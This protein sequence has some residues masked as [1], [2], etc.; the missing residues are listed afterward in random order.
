MLTTSTATQTAWASGGYVAGNKA[1][2]R[3]TVQKLAV[4]FHDY[5]LAKVVGLDLKGHGYFTSLYWGQTDVPAELP[6]L[7]SIKWARNVEQD[8]ATCTIELYNTAPLPLGTTPSDDH[9]WEQ[10]GFYSL[11]RGTGSNRWGY[12]VTGWGD[13]L[14]PDRIIRTYQGYGANYLVPPEQDP[15]LYPSGVWMIDKVNL[16]VN[17]ILTLECRDIGRVLLEQIAMPPVVP[18][19]QYPVSWTRALDVNNDGEIDETDPAWFRPNYG[20]DSNKDYVGHGI[21]DA[22]VPV[23]SSGGAVAGHKGEDAFDSSGTSYWLSVGERPNSDQAYPFVQGTFGSKTISAVRVKA[24]GGPYVMFIS[25]YADGE[26]KGRAKIPYEAGS[27]VD[28]SADIKFVKK[29]VVKLGEDRKVKLPRAYDDAT[30]IRLTF[31]DLWNSD[32][33]TNRRYRA[34]VKDVK[35]LGG[36]DVPVNAPVGSHVE[37]NYLDYTDIVKWFLCWGGFYWFRDDTLTFQTHTDGSLHFYSPGMA[38]PVFPSDR[39]QIWGD[40]EQSGTY[41]PATL[42][43][44]IFDKKPIM[45]CVNYVREIIAFNFYVDEFGGAIFRSPNIWSVGNYVT[46][47]TGPAITGTN[48]QSTL[49]HTGTPIVIDEDTTL[50]DLTASVSSRGIRERVFIANTTGKVGA[51]APGYN[52]LYPEVTGLRRVGGWTDQRFATEAECQKMADLITVRQV[53]SYRTD[54]ITI[55]GNPALQIDDQVRIYERVTAESFLHYVKGIS[56]D[57]SAD[58]GQWTYELETCWLGNTPFTD[59][60][61]DPNDLAAETKAYLAAIGKI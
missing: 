43:V 27:V 11:G 2:M 24:Y 20:T 5:N 1:V 50:V 38:D 40:L 36:P 12:A 52:P 42:T 21:T 9:D 25:V 13:R 16:S 29:I 3:A 17:G 44:D 53:M 47:A 31:T 23:V 39:G 59:W 51:V 60:V 14:R 4:S 49:P 45:D 28:T 41:G 15:N 18:Y 8:V 33:G 56:S 7:K 57:W 6:N 35:V 19:A 34:G 37:G 30:K 10:P 26:W 22:G 61:F 48:G 58:T 46:P 32:I 54:S 55:P